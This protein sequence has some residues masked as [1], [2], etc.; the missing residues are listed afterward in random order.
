MP[1]SLLSFC[2]MRQRPS[3]S[4]VLGSILLP[5]LVPP[6]GRPSL[7][8]GCGS[9]MAEIARFHQMKTNMVCVSSSGTQPRACMW[10]PNSPL[11]ACDQNGKRK[12]PKRQ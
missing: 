7:K 11:G 6:M 2:S 10:V 1:Q 5:R 3:Q 4:V 8:A 12:L 9:D